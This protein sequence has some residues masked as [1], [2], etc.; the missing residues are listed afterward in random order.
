MAKKKVKIDPG[1]GEQDSGASSAYGKEKV[2]TL[3][4]AQKV[5]ALFKG[6]KYIDISLTRSGD[7]Y[8]SLTDR[9]KQAERDKVD[10]FISIHANSATTLSANGTETFYS[11]ANSKALADIL[12]KNMMAAT[13]LRDRGVKTANFQVIKQTT[14]PAILLEVGFISSSIDGPLLFNPTF[15]HS[16]AERIAMGIC[17]Y[18]NVPYKEEEAAEEV[19]KKVTE[20]QVAVNNQK[21]ATGLLID[22]VSYIPARLVN[23]YLN[24]KVF[25]DQKNKRVDIYKEGEK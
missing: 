7:T 10:C 23:H 20:V 15:Q 14:M 21:V 9:V 8:P 22:G 5:E 25:W 4:I 6:H 18:F 17:E 12:H 13:K 2:F 24:G 3:I 19:K 11:R 1:H 16:V